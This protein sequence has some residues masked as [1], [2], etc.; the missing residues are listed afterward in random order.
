M[1]NDIQYIFYKEDESN[2]IWLVDTNPPMKHGSLLFSFDKQKVYSFFRDYPHALSD[3]ERAIFDTEFP[4]W[5][6]NYK[7]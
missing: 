1:Q 6:S 2:A 3:E 5:A 4:W 7:Q